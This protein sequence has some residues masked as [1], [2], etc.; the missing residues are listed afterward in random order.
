MIRK[1]QIYFFLT[2]TARTLNTAEGLNIQVKYRER[3]LNT[4]SWV[5]SETPPP[6]AIE[7]QN[8]VIL[9]R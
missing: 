2:Y 6:P 8:Y 7:T 5:F 4:T 9:L 3:V 1:L